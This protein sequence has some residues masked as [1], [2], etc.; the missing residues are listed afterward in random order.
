VCTQTATRFNALISQRMFQAAAQTTTSDVA[1]E[2][3][4]CMHNRS[5]FDVSAPVIVSCTDCNGP[6]REPDNVMST[7]MSTVPAAIGHLTPSHAMVPV[8]KGR[9][10]DFAE[11][12][13]PVNFWEM[14]D[15][16]RSISKVPPD[17]ALVQVPEPVTVVF[18]P[19]ASV[20]GF[21]PVTVPGV[22]PPPQ[23]F[24]ANFNESAWA[25][26]NTAEPKR[27]ARISNKAGR[28]C[29]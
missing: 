29:A 27:T 9:L 3:L 12:K 20:S 10:N 8:P 22:E 23:S 16:F 15:A 11:H 6:G 28:F 1:G 17:T 26:A 5:A 24:H 7:G 2:V 14:I 18:S 13:S 19:S 4:I 21:K 25:S